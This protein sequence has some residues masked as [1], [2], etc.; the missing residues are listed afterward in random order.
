M[1]MTR[2]FSV[3]T[4]AIYLLALL[5]ASVSARAENTFFVEVGS[6]VTLECSVEAKRQSISNLMGPAMAK[7]YTD[8]AIELNIRSE[9]S[10]Y[11]GMIMQNP[12]SAVVNYLPACS[13]SSQTQSKPQSNSSTDSGSTT[14]FGTTTVTTTAPAGGATSTVSAWVCPTGTDP[15]F[16]VVYEMS[17]SAAAS[18]GCV[19]R[20]DIPES[21]FPKKNEMWECSAVK[22]RMGAKD[23]MESLKD[24]TDDAHFYVAGCTVVASKSAD[25][26]CPNGDRITSTEIKRPYDVQVAIDNGCLYRDEINLESFDLDDEYAYWTCTDGRNHS[27]GTKDAIYYV[28]GCEYVDGDIGQIERKFEDYG[29]DFKD[30]R[31]WFIQISPKE[32]DAIIRAGGDSQIFKTYQEMLEAARAEFIAL[33]NAGI[34]TY[35]RFKRPGRYDP[36]SEPCLDLTRESAKSGDITSE[37]EFVFIFQRCWAG[38]AGGASAP[39][40]LPKYI[41]EDA[42]FEKLAQE[43]YEIPSAEAMENFFE[44]VS[45]GFTEAPGDGGQQRWIDR[46]NREFPGVLKEL[47]LGKKTQRQLERE[48]T[49]NAK[50]LELQEVLNLAID[51]NCSESGNC[52][53]LSQADLDDFEDYCREIITDLEESFASGADEYNVSNAELAW[54]SIGFDFTRIPKGQLSRLKNETRDSVCSD[55][56][57]IYES[58]M[59]V[60]QVFTNA[61]GAQEIHYF[62][63]TS[64]AENKKL[65]GVT[66]ANRAAWFPSNSPQVNRFSM[67]RI[68]HTSSFSEEKVYYRKCSVDFYRLPESGGHI[69]SSTRTKKLSNDTLKTVGLE[70]KRKA[71]WGME[72]TSFNSENSNA[73]FYM[74]TSARWSRTDADRGIDEITQA[75]DESFDYMEDAFDWDMFYSKILSSDRGVFKKLELLK[76]SREEIEA[77]LALPECKAALDEAREE[78]MLRARELGAR[79]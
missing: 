1:N 51:V 40:L 42:D 64:S 36:I 14:G 37:A 75:A 7:M 19:K 39:S 26:V 18:A 17:P 38:A 57:D 54:A 77:L 3:A 12:Q 56:R 71:V 9:V 6:S 47:G 24:S 13:L 22:K 11:A 10:A 50:K 34:P 43:N 5:V 45:Y 60:K 33:G 21:E 66:D 25:L 35:L 62:L 65:T 52:T 73:L 53:S 15:N 46:F 61:Q 69:Y 58:T 32:K 44:N 23:V 2:N 70:I 55:Y 68:T 72:Y 8:E 27:V 4:E 31:G 29:P 74:P 49:V 20:S 78:T 48:N 67:K 30:D 28:Q 79:S 59:N 76:T 63:P 41:A 16:D